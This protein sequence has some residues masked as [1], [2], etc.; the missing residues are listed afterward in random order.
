MSFLSE[1]DFHEYSAVISK[2]VGNQMN[3]D[4]PGKQENKHGAVNEKTT[5]NDGAISSSNSIFCSF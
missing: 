1:D 5:L 2:P 4:K 3:E